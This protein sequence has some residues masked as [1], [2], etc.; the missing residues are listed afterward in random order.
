M[1]YIICIYMSS[2]VKE[3]AT[4]VTVKL[5][6]TGST[7]Y[8]SQGR[9]LENHTDAITAKAASKTQAHGFFKL[10]RRNTKLKLPVADMRRKSSV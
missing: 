10:L 9:Q 3:L 1:N 7:S 6:Y 2:L 4:V 8:H 5:K